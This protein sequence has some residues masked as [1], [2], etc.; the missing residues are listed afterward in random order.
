MF[1]R[2]FYLKPIST[3]CA[4]TAVKP[5]FEPM[6]SQY[7]FRRENQSFVDAPIAL[8]CDAA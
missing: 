6:M 7:N 3:S 8:F 2:L 4:I 1:L 5:C